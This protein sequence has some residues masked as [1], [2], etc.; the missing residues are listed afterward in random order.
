MNIFKPPGAAQP[1]PSETP[2]DIARE[3]ER[4]AQADVRARARHRSRTQEV[5]DRRRHRG[6][7]A[8]HAGASRPHRLRLPARSR[9]PG[10]IPVHAR[11]PAGDEPHRSVRGL[12]LFG[13]RRRAGVQPALP[14]ADRDRHRADP[15]R[16]RSADPVR[17]RFRS[18]DGGGRGRQCRGRHRHARRH[19]AVVRGHP[20]RQP[21]AHRHAR[22]LDR[23]DRA[24]AL[25]RARREAGHP[26]AALHGQSAERSAQGIYRARH[27]N[28]AAGAGRQARHR[29]GRLVRRARP[30]LVAD[31]GLRQSHQRR[32]RWLEHG[33][34]DRARQCPPLH[35]A[36]A[37]A[38]LFDRP[39][40]AAPA[41]VPGRAA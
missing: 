41:H 18:R 21:Q 17:L 9:L 14:Q 27:A 40:G 37:G 39:G 25:R 35:R 22:Q 6:R 38:G 5:L 4:W 3:S 32:R 26:L 29:R 15:G 16:A 12:G 30:E 2:Q 34:R 33:H 20:G 1:V 31:D 8:L 28:P 10:R 36:A 11:R 7:S 24:R 23:P 19:G 13:V